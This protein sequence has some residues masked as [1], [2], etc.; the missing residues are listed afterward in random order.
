MRQTVPGDLAAADAG[1]IASFLR[2]RLRNPDSGW[3]RD[4]PCDLPWDDP[5][6]FEAMVASRNQ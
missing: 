4:R 1:T 6:L 2:E 5:A 3:L